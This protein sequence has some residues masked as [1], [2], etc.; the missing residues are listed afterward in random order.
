LRDFPTKHRGFTNSQ[1]IKKPVF[2]QNVR[3][4]GDMEMVDSNSDNV[5]TQEFLWGTGINVAEISSKCRNFIRNFYIEDVVTKEKNMIYL[6]QLMEFKHNEVFRLNIDGR[7]LKL[8]DKLLYGQIINFPSE[9]IPIFDIVANTLYSDLNE[10]DHKEQSNNIQVRIF[11]L[12][13]SSRIR[14]LGSQDIDKLVM[15]KGIVVRCSEIVPEMREAYFKCSICQK[16]ESATLQRSKIIEPIECANCKAKFSFE[17]IHNRSIFNDK[18]HVKIQETPEN[19]PEGETPINIHL[20]CYDELVDYV[21]PGD[22]I[23]V[24]GIYRAQGIRVNPRLRT[25][26]AIYKT[27]IDVVSFEK[28]KNSSLSFSHDEEMMNISESMKNDIESLSKN[29]NIYQILT[30]SFAPSIWENDDVKKGLLLQLFGGVNKEF[31]STGRGKFR[32]DI[33][34]ILVGDPSTAKSQLLQYVN[35]LAPRGIYTS[36]KGSS[37]VGLTAYI[38]KDPETREVILESGALVLSDKGICCIDEFDKMDDKTRVILH[39]AMEQQTISIAKAGIICQLNARTAILAS[40]NPVHSKYDPK[41]SVVQNIRLPPSLLSRFDL[42]YLVLDRQSE[43][44]DRKLANHIISLYGGEEDDSDDIALTKNS[45]CLSKEL[46]TAYITLARKHNPSLHESVI[47]D[48]IKEYVQI[49][50]S[51]SSKSTITA[52]PRQLESMIRLAEAR[53]RLRFSKYV[54]KEDIDEAIRLI[55]IATQKAATDP[56]TGLI[57]MDMISTGITASSRAIVAKL[58]DN[59]KNILRENSEIARK[60]IKQ[61]NL[62]DELRRRVDLKEKGDV[63]K[64]SEFDLRDALRALEEENVIICLGHKNSQTIRYIAF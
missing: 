21:K 41:I 54:E 63:N 45:S 13:N 10:I 40:A 22:K 28:S 11:N 14:E 53:A 34:V 6:K 42:I 17:I 52:T 1:S 38:T 16:I 19:M 56:T 26:K 24:V 61:V 3:E 64:F 35:K 25:T 44:N 8:H 7:H 5:N 49:R 43:T 33:N 27:Y 39:E 55:K 59:I 48:L 58:C 32:G 31:E 18:Q 62:V 20:C 2:H 57:D 60:G 36:G 29:P 30:D 50:S 9:M 4:Q 47:Q 23:E 51:G 15:L 37:V 46:F 12:E